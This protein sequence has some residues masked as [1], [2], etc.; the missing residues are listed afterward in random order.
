[1]GHGHTYRIVVSDL[2]EGRPIWFGGQDRSEASLDAFYAWLGPEKSK[3][4]RLAVMDMWKAFRS[5]TRKPQ[6]APQA[7][8]LY[9]KFHVLRHLHEAMDKVREA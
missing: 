1:M 8:I 2:R 3:E 6:N 7:T 9:D 4:I 5:S